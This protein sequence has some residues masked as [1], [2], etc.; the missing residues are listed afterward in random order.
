MALKITEQSVLEFLP[1]VLQH[2]LQLNTCYNMLLSMLNMHSTTKL[3]LL[4]LKISIT[5][6][7]SRPCSQCIVS[8]WTLHSIEQWVISGL[9]ASLTALTDQKLRSS[10]LCLAVICMLHDLLTCILQLPM[11]ILCTND[12]FLY[13]AIQQCQFDIKISFRKVIHAG[14]YCKIISV[15][16]YEAYALDIYVIFYFCFCLLNAT[17]R[18]L[19][20][21]YSIHT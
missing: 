12:T 19:C 21:S 15:L 2:I 1:C 5:L 11:F 8:T 3:L 14:T 7:V 10:T 6:M 20:S 4:M 17:L 18:W 9:Q 16:L 13:Y